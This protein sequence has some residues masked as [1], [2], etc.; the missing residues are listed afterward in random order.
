[1]KAS[2]PKP[3]RTWREQPGIWGSCAKAEE[4]SRVIPEGLA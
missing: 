4:A 3:G 2:V 1:M